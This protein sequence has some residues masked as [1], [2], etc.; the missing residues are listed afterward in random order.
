M[1]TPRWRR[2]QHPAEGRLLCV[3]VLDR[4]NVAS[5]SLLQFATPV[6]GLEACT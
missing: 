6:S 5:D 4:L 1:T 2:R 3:P